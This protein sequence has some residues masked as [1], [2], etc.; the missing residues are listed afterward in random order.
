MTAALSRASCWSF[1]TLK[2]ACRPPTQRLS[3]KWPAMPGTAIPRLGS[4]DENRGWADSTRQEP[5]FSVLE[6]ELCCC[7]CCTLLRR[8]NCEVV[9]L[10]ILDNNLSCVALYVTASRIIA[11]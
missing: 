3:L 2:S 5:G 1:S 11:G 6:G 7:A 8:Q 10:P 4:N 9:P